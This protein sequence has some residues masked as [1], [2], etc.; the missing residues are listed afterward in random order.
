[1]G[2]SNG[3][4]IQEAAWHEGRHW[5]RGDA[6]LSHGSVAT[7]SGR[8]PHAVC[9]AI[10]RGSLRAPRSRRT[11]ELLYVFGGFTIP[12]ERASWL[13]RGGG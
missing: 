12:R 11:A 7:D 8:A 6:E 1:M 4:A 9:H 5:L 3:R 10:D 13:R 2:S